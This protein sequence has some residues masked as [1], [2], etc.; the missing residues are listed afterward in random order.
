MKHL[1]VSYWLF[2]E[3]R[4]PTAIGHQLIAYK[5]TLL[6]AASV[7]SKIY[8][9]LPVAAKTLFARAAKMQ[10]E[11]GERL[12]NY[13]AGGAAAAVVANPLPGSDFISI[14]AVQVAMT[15][16]LGRLYNMEM[17]RQVAVALL[18]PVL[19]SLFSS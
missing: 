8:E 12:V 10:H 4:Q 11:E 2:A 19:N 3:R 16:H 6:P 18:T 15:I 13:Y 7:L 5:I 14:S 1:A 17:T 9:L